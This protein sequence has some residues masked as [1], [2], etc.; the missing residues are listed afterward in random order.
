MNK[1]MQLWMHSPRCKDLCRLPKRLNYCTARYLQLSLAKP[2]LFF[3]FI[4]GDEKG[5]VTLP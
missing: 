1:Y 2:D 3:F 5:L 4:C